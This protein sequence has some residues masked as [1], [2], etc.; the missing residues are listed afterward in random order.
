MESAPKGAA[1]AAPPDETHHAWWRVEEP[2]T[3]LWALG[4]GLAG[5]LAFVPVGAW[6]L[7]PLAPLGLFIALRNAST[8]GAAFRRLLGGAWVMYFGAIQWLTTIRVYAPF[9]P[10][11][12]IGIMALA[13]LMAAMLALP[14][15]ALRRWAWPEHRPAL[16]FAGFSACWLLVEWFR[17][18]GRLANPLAE[19]GHAWAPHAWLIQVAEYGGELAVSAQILFV[20]GL[21]FTWSYA[22]RFHRTTRG[23]H[24]GRNP[25]LLAALGLLLLFAL[26]LQNLMMM[27]VWNSRVRQAA[28]KTGPENALEVAIHQPNVPQMMKLASYTD[29]RPEVRA[30][31]T[32]TMTKNIETSV[33]LRADPAWELL[34]LPETTFTQLD[35]FTNE[36]MQ[37]RAGAIAR[38]A[39]A[40]M[41]F[42]A[43]RHLEPLGKP[44]MFNSAY[45]ARA[46]G[47]LDKAF[48][49]KMRLVPFG[50]ALPYFDLI[51]GFQESIVGIGSFTEGAERVL[52]DT[53]GFRFGVLICFESTFSQMARAF[54][55]E[56]AD[57]LTMITNDA[58]YGTS[59][60]AAAHFNLSLLRAVE[61]RRY[62]VRSANTGISALITPA[63]V[64][65]ESL[66]L[67]EQGFIEGTIYPGLFEDETFFMRWGNTWLIAAA[68]AALA[69]CAGASFFNRR[70]RRHGAAD[71]AA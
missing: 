17:T 28:E 16:Q 61:T 71:T 67:G 22:I 50:E 14:V 41:V 31:L 12:V 53:Q 60:G 64:I 70:K 51:P 23:P 63:G 10:V 6:F 3:W 62:V 35:F 26:G 29:S 38:T 39:G 13:L 4:G 44:D 15:W 5:A 47:T 9:P 32:E 36:P 2:R 58:W 69:G 25:I 59:A 49:D 1:Q 68:L 66:P 45:L 57:F 8:P 48:Y 20:A 40:D 37:R 7:A 42:G 21:I 33:S 34:V 11:A 30:W 55:L 54:A 24:Y 56:G 27:L 65:A 43:D 19:I 46:D 52:F 18:I